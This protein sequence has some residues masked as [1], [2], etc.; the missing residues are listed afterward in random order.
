MTKSWIKT[1]IAG[2]C[3]TLWSA[4]AISATPISGLGFIPN[5]S[6][7]M[8]FL[9]VTARGLRNTDQYSVHIARASVHVG[10]LAAGYHSVVVYGM[11][12]SYHGYC[13]LYATDLATG[14][15]YYSYGS[16]SGNYGDRYGYYVTLYLPQTS[17]YSVGMQ[18]SIQENAELWGVTSL[19]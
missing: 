9:Q 1:A 8:Q 6:S 18:C 14:T 12:G 15:Y 5:S 16:D 19:S 13:Y 11:V 17:T 7:D 10:S 3:V 4:T 2:V